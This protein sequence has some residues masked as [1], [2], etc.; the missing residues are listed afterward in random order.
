MGAVGTAAAFVSARQPAP[1]AWLV[2]WLVA[3]LIAMIGGGWALRRKAAA[4]ELPL[5]S[6]LGRKF[7]LGLFSPLFV[8]DIVTAIR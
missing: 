6:G 3:A 2:T 8:G 7:L 1:E 5:L 4:Q